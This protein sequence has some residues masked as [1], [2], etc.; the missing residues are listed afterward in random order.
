MAHL[1]PDEGGKSGVEDVVSHLLVQLE[2]IRRRN[3]SS[4]GMDVLYLLT[5]S[6]FSILLTRAWNSHVIAVPV[7]PVDFL[8]YFSWSAAIGGI[9]LLLLLV[10]GL[11][12]SKLFFLSQLAVMVITILLSRAGLLPL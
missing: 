10:F 7:V 6:F 4:L 3:M 5:V 8:V 1:L 11:R 2:E 9:P 12:S